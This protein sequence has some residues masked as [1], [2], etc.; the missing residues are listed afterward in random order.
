MNDIRRPIRLA[1]SLMFAALLA[2]TACGDS[3]SDSATDDGAES[4]GEGAASESGDSGACP[5]EP[6]TGTISSPGDDDNEAFELTDGDVVAAEAVALTDGVQYTVYLADADISGVVGIETIEADPGQ[7]VV[8]M[9]ARS[10]D[11][12]DIEPGATYEEDFVILD[13]GGGAQGAPDDPVGSV[14][15]IEVS[16]DHIC[17]AVDYVD[18]TPGHVLQ[19]TVSADVVPMLGAE[20]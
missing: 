5:A 6:F 3:D 4:S 1:A 20:S 8:T 9:Q 2:L 17:F 12:G 13:S 14:T 15:F 16:D 7:V 18:A 19:G 11:G 10:D